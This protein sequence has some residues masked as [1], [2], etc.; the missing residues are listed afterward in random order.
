MPRR[1]SL[2]G[3]KINRENAVDNS[4]FGFEQLEYRVYTQY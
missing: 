2:L 4:L 1:S 3:D